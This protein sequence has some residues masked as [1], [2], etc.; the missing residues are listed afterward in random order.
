MRRLLDGLLL[1]NSPKADW[2]TLLRRSHSIDVLECPKCRARLRPMAA[3]R[4]EE[5]AKRFLQFI[6]EYDEPRP[7]SRARDPTFD[8]V[9]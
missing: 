5:Q 9:A 3:I 8:D 1:M 2:A 7:L 6:D 4:D